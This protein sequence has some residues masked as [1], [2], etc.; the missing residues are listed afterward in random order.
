MSAENVQIK[1]NFKIF[2]NKVLKSSPNVQI[3]I[4][5]VSL[6]SCPNLFNDAFSHYIK[7][8]NS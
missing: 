7:L 2:L 8:F 4:V 5:Y 1:G 6:N 3:Y